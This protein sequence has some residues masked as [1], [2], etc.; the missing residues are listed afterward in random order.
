[1]FP[2]LPARPVLVLANRAEGRIIP[3]MTTAH[4][5]E[6]IDAMS[7]EGRF[8]ASAYLHHLS[9]EADPQH[10]ATLSTRMTRMDEG[11]KFTLDQLV[12]VHQQ[13]ERQGL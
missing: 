5:R 1:M 13:L 3:F 10:K 9:N 11:H 2:S 6:Q 7:D 12:D 8:F 4:I